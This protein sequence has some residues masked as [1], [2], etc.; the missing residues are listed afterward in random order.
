MHEILLTNSGIRNLIRDNKI[1]QIQSLMQLGTKKGM[2]IMKDSV[3]N[4]LHQGTISSE[5]AKKALNM[6]T[7]LDGDNDEKM[8]SS[9][10]SHF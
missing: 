10:K 2:C 5:E 6:A 4:L 3:F 8:L 9:S 1:A 7:S